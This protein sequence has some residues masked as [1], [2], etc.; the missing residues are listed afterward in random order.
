MGFVLIS[1]QLVLLD[2]CVLQSLITRVLSVTI[3][4]G[5]TRLVVHWWKSRAIYVSKFDII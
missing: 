5:Y 1:A 2:W 3:S 4:C